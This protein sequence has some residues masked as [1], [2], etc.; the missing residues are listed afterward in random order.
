MV[1]EIAGW[2]EG[3]Y[4]LLCEAGGWLPIVIWA[5]GEWPLLGRCS[6]WVNGR[7]GARNSRCIRT[8]CDAECSDRLSN[9][10]SLGRARR[11]SPRVIA[12]RPQS[13][14]ITG[15][16]F[17]P[18]SRRSHPLSRFGAEILGR[19]G[20]AAESPRDLRQYAFS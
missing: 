11:V 15:N 19:L 20:N 17:D 7:N 18:R 1:A 4:L 5:Q 14:R 10:A 3:F 6:M 8:M 2:S 16:Y 13:L 12:I 9:P